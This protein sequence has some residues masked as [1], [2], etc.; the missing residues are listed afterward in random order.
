MLLKLTNI[1]YSI[2]YCTILS[3]STGRP[4]VVHYRFGLAQRLD[5]LHIHLPE[6]QPAPGTG[7]QQA[8]DRVGSGG[9]GVGAAARQ[10]ARVK[11]LGGGL[12]KDLGGRLED[13]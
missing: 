5:G 6:R 9:E 8:V 3:I 4:A 13:V 12:S 7:G 10:P 1:S 2:P 11:D